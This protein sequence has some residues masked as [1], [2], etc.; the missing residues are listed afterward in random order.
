MS[1]EVAE[2]I[3]VKEALSWIKAQGWSKVE[4][5][6]DSLLVVQ[7][8]RSFTEMPSYFGQ[9]VSDCRHLLSS[10]NQHF[11]SLKFVRHSANRVAHHL[12]RSTCFVSDHMLGAQDVSPN[13]L[14]VL[15]SDL[16]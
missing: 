16:V 13:L 8:I 14:S 3:G 9:I 4:L 10:L 15:Y 2:A 7:S 1:P 5:E 12:A 6:S 11:V